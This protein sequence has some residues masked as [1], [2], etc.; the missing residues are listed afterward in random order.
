MPTLNVSV[1]GIRDH[2]A[3]GRQEGGNVLPLDRPESTGGT[4]LGFNGGHLMLLGWGAC[5][6][7]TLVAAADARDIPIERLSL[8]ISGDLVDGP[9]RFAAIRMDVVLEGP[10]S[11][12]DKQKLIT[13]ARNGCAVSNTLARALEMDVRLA[14]D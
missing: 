14:T 1:E 2:V 9:F 12:D 8:A 4:G 10:A 11:Y 6:K 3:I 13:I 7:S 5:F